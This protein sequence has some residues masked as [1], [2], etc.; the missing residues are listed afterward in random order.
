VSQAGR[1]RRRTGYRGG[2]STKAQDESAAVHRIVGRTLTS[3]PA[4]VDE[5]HWGGYC[6][7]DRD[8]HEVVGSCAFKTPPSDDGVAETAY[9]TYPGFEGRGYATT[10]A[11]ELVE[12]ASKSAAVRRVI[13]H[14]LPEKNAST[15]VLERVG[16]TFVGEVMDPE[17]GRVWRWQVEVGA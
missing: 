15:R 3:P 8:T 11:R 16:M 10:M 5:P 4:T 7:V 2:R 1:A 6:V 9:F 14:T 17:D 12:L 13:A